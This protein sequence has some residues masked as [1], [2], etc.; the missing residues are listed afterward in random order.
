MDIIVTDAPDLGA[1][2]LILAGLVAYNE[3]QVGPSEARPLA[4]LVQDEEQRVLGGLWAWTAYG[5]LSIELLF[6]PLDL[7]CRDLGRQVMRR[8]EEEARRRGC[9]EAWLDTFGF[10][11]K[12]FYERLGYTVFGQLDGYPRGSARYFMRNAL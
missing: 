7:R 8:A 12:G 9:R 3:A 2:E 6:L 4:V 1:H 10:Q 11:A 5:W